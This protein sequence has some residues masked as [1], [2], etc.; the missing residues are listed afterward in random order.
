MSPP[1]DQW[2]ALLVAAKEGFDSVA[3][4]LLDH[5]ANIHQK[6]MVRDNG[7]IYIHTFDH[8]SF[9]SMITNF[10]STNFL[11]SNVFGVSENECTFL[12]KLIHFHI[13]E[14]I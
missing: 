9:S 1:Q 4:T 12:V 13:F 8:Y 3:A 11:S 6:D 2:C 10:L 14:S 7:Y 5:G